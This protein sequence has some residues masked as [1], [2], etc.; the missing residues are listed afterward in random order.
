MGPHEVWA[1]LT[2]HFGVDMAIATG[3][4]LLTATGLSLLSPA[5]KD[6][7]ARWLMGTEGSEE[8][9]SRSFTA[10]FDAIFGTRHFSLRCIATSVLASLIAV[11]VLWL[12]MGLNEGFGTRLEAAHGLGTVLLIGL[13]VNAAADYVS[14]LETRWLL[15][16][17]DRWRHPLV[18]AL[19]LLVDLALTAAIIW[20]ALWLFQQTDWYDQ[21]TGGDGEDLGEVLLVFSPFAVFF[22]S[23]F[24]TSV[25]TWVYILSTWVMRGL[26][27]LR[28]GRVFD[29]AGSPVSVLLFA[30]VPVIVVTGFAA[31]AAIGAL[32]G[33]DNTG[34]TL[35]DRAVCSVTR[36]RACLAVA[37]LTEDEQQR[38]SMILAA[39]SGGIT[40]ECWNRGEAIWESDGA[41]AAQYWRTSCDAG[42]PKSCINLGVLHYEGIGMD[43]D[44]EEAARLYQQGCD[45]GDALGCTNLGWLHQRGIGMDPDAGEAA[46]LY[47]QGCDGGHAGGCTN[48]GVLHA[49]GIGVDPDAGEAARL[50]QLGCDGGHARG[51]TNLGG[52]HWQGIGMDPDAEEAA[53][54]YQQGCDGGDAA[55]CTN[56]GVMH[57][58]GIGMDPDAGEAARLYQQGCDGG[59]AAGCYNLGLMHEFEQ[60][61][62]AE[63][64]L[65]QGVFQ[66]ACD[67]GDTAGCDRAEAL[68]NTAETPE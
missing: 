34:L 38:L 59:E 37:N 9:W 20:A 14:L 46:R 5:R 7:I 18:Q 30:A 23:T 36:D 13:F 45:S 61:G 32:T 65:A 29:V 11:V 12:L 21:I 39:C 35:M 62:A 4:T 63:F 41:L 44:A 19:V 68:N 3:F 22:Y 16:R 49:N 48:L 33:K 24:V 8:S 2:A 31:S 40:Q 64:G 51:C 27:R 60:F 58:E 15:G 25:W 17:I 6:A 66:R 56:L 53:R 10:I 54:L 50:Y 42:E 52:M 47:Q 26:A 43:P 67:L 55:G 1:F 57:D 28:L